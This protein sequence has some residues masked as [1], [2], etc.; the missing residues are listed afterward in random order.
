MKVYLELK[1]KKYKMPIFW[2]NLIIFVYNLETIISSSCNYT[3]PIKKGD[4]CTI[5]ECSKEDFDSN[6]CTIENDIIKDQWFSSI[7]L[8]TEKNINYATL[9]TT[10][11]GDLICTSTYSS[12]TKKYYYGIKK[13][14]RPYFLIDNKETY[15]ATSDSNKARNEGN[16]YAIKLSGSTDNK[17]YVIAFGNNDSNFELYDFD[18]NDVYYKETKSFFD[19][20][21][22]TF[23]Y[24]SVLKL[25]INDNN[26][27]IISFIAKD[28]N[29]NFFFILRNFS[30]QN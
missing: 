14:G 2:L 25:N 30:L 24:G 15:F 26:Y 17:E 11:N 28:V 9:V 13:N 4:I 27:Y 3:H 8:F 5:G 22:T 21:Y 12:L 19:I 16:I 18:N 10:P 23:H 1:G 6:I 7:I 29:N 20:N